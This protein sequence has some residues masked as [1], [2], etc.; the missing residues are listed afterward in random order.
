MM[1][2]VSSLLSVFDALKGDLLQ[3]AVILFGVHLVKYAI[4][5]VRSLAMPE[6]SDYRSELQYEIA[7]RKWEVDN[8][9][10]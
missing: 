6:R 5:R 1:I 4:L 8:D 2:P 10:T 9:R 3:W 7:L